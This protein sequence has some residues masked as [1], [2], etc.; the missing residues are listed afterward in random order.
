MTARA[1]HLD[2]SANL[3]RRGRWWWILV[4][5][6]LALALP[7]A[8]YG[9][10]YLANPLRPSLRSAETLAA[11]QEML[12]A[13]P[14]FYRNAVGQG[15][16]IERLELGIDPSGL[17]RIAEKRA[18]ALRVGVLFA[19]RDDL[20]DASLRLG[21]QTLGAR[22]RLKGDLSDHWAGDR[23]SLRGEV[24]REEVTGGGLTGGG[25]TGD[26]L[27]MRRFSLHA[28]WTRGFHREAVFFDV[29]RHHG[30][31][32]PRAEIV[33]LVLG[34]R[35]IGLMELEQHVGS[36]LL[37]GD[38]RRGIF[39]RFDED[40]L[41]REWVA[42][43]ERLG[44]SWSLE[45]PKPRDAN[46]WRSA[47]IDAFESREIRA[48]AELSRQLDHAA[49]LLRSAQ[50]GSR[51]PSEVFDAEG[52]GT[53]LAHCEIFGAVHMA[54][55]NNLRFFYDPATQRLHPVAFDT[56]VLPERERAPSTTA[57][58]TDTAQAT[59]TVQPT[60][61][62]QATNTVQLDC[63]GGELAFTSTLVA[64]PA[65]RTEL[66]QALRRLDDQVH[67]PSF[68]ALLRQQEPRY[69]A[70]LH[71]EFPWLKPFD[72]GAARRRAVALRGVDAE[73][74]IRR[75]APATREPG[76][77]FLKRRMTVRLSL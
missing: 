67:D 25:P 56:G 23:W 70:P 9:R 65:I 47:P 76:Y 48:S 34:G 37:N 10:L 12:A 38:R 69:L 21:E 6:V 72:L 2:R 62:V 39:L 19:S 52:W 49:E 58:P 17:R 43:A 73:A 42:A 20:V 41:W 18:E 29:L 71:T 11:A 54:L 14:A 68:E 63:V 61:T 30:V 3:H 24:T 28:P 27:G 31:L 15:P 13:V 4:L 5:A 59:N 55:W 22:V 46:D 16:R 51:L 35:D 36:G 66:L 33:R 8:H 45:V 64:D 32:A 60:D 74:S 40:R 50:D 44:V 26:V 57:Q 1:T 75:V 7:L 77:S 53:F